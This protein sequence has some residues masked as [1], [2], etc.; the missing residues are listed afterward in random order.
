SDA[1]LPHFSKAG[2]A[3]K[4]ISVVTNGVSFDLFSQP[5][6]PGPFRKL[7]NLENKFL[8]AYVGTLGL[9]HNLDV[10]LAAADRLRSREDIAFV[11][12]GDGAERDRLVEQC[13]AMAL[14]NVRILPQVPHEQVPLIWAACDA[15]IVTLRSVSTFERVIP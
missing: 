4:N 2:V 13:R 1:Y 7:H 8:A 9:A 5:P 11:L 10:V 12:V 15:A 3:R 14:P 6:D